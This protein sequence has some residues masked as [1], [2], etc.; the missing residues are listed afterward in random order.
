MAE[1]QATRENINNMEKHNKDV[2]NIKV[3][4]DFLHEILKD[5]YANYWNLKVEKDILIVEQNKLQRDYK[6]ME[7]ILLKQQKVL[8]ELRMKVGNIYRAKNDIQ[9]QAY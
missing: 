5:I 1:L 9:R 2:E 7:Q 4:K 6:N 8:E 3:E